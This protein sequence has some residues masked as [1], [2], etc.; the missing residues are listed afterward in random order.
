MCEISVVRYLECESEECEEGGRNGEGVSGEG[1]GV[2]EIKNPTLRMW[3][4]NTTQHHTAQ[5]DTTSFNRKQHAKEQ[6]QTN[7]QQNTQAKNN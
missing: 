2:Q 3:G 6:K 1:G 7:Q 5:H 4:T